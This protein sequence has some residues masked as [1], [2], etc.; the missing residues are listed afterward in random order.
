MCHAEP[1]VA[2]VTRQDQTPAYGDLRRILQYL[3]WQ[4]G[5][6]RGRPWLLKAPV[7]LPALGVLMATFPKAT[8]VHCHRDVHQ[9]VAS[10]AKLYEVAHVAFGADHVELEQIGRNTLLTALGWE[11]NLA[12]RPA[13]P[14]TQIL[15]VHYEQICSDVT[16]VIE[17][18]LARRGL[19]H[20]P[21]TIAAIR[22]WERTN[23][24]YRHGRATYSL[25]RYGLTPDQVDEAFSVYTAAF[26]RV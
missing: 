1:F 19:G 15:D 7:H 25:E 6:R 8:V 4:D 3:Q 22:A 26:S 10:A 17:E 9:T 24:Q 11:A 23:P 13:V 14:P 16:D 5:G 18:I 12:Q 2:W 20:E 21:Q